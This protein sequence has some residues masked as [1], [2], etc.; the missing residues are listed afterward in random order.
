MPAY[1]IDFHGKEFVEASRYDVCFLLTEVFEKKQFF[2]DWSIKHLMRLSQSH[3]P[4]GVALSPNA[5]WNT[6][7]LLGPA[8]SEDP[9][10]YRT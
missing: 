8:N 9:M 1:K 3:P 5:S 10:Y 6:N 2:L 7:T 4:A